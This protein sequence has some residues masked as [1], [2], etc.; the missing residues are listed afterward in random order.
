M[1]QQTFGLKS[2]TTGRN[3][4]ANPWPYPPAARGAPGAE[5]PDTNQNNEYYIGD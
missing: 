3:C 5:Q 2:A 1:M 4:G